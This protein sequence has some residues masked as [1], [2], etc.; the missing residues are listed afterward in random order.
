MSELSTRNVW[1]ALGP[2]QVLADVTLRIGKGE[3]VG[4]V[5]SNGSGK[6]SLLSVLGGQIAPDRGQVS[7][8]G[9][10][11]NVMPPHMRARNGIARI[12]QDSRMWQGMTVAEH[13]DLAENACAPTGAQ[14]RQ[15][16]DAFRITSHL[17]GETSERMR[18]LDR[19]RVELCSAMFGAR[20]L[21]AD[22]LAAGLSASEGESLYDS[23]N[24]AVL[25]GWIDGA[26]L[27]EH[28]HALL[29][30]FCSAFLHMSPS[31]VARAASPY[32]TSPTA[33]THGVCT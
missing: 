29:E 5:G 11:I 33:P 14:M 20:F 3:V 12:F 31:G 2:T 30:R 10:V 27:A 19:R 26:L 23:V 9:M 17:L 28:R 22:E 6:T 8:N 4:L 25:L 32:G 13:L 1:L 7:L 24:R 18:L 16:R 15:L 21:L